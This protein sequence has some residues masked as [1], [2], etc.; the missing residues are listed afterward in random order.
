VCGTLLAS[1]LHSPS[2]RIST[3]RTIGKN[4]CIRPVK[5]FAPKSVFFVVFVSYFGGGGVLLSGACLSI[6]FY[7]PV[8]VL[9]YWVDCYVPVSVRSRELPYCLAFTTILSNNALGHGACY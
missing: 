6:I 7:I 9:G 4:T 2:K 5:E 3:V 1:L 8:S